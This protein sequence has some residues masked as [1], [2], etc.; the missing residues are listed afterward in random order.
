MKVVPRAVVV[1]GTASLLTDLSS[2]M[3]YPL[4]PLFLSTQ[5]GASALALGVIE[6]V[7]ETTASV[8]KIF[9]GVWTD[10]IQRRKPFIVA[11][12][13]LAG[14]ARPLV[15][16]ATAWPQVLAIR[17]CDRVGKGVRTSPRD[18]LIA[19]TVH[20]DHRGAAFGFH[21]MM[22]NAGAVLGPLVATLLLAF[23]MPLRTVFLCAIVPSILVVLIQVFFLHEA[24]VARA[25]EEAPPRVGLRAGW[26]VLDARYK[27]LLLSI[28]VFTLGAS[29]DAFILM[30]LNEAGISASTV[31]LLWSLHHVVKMVSSYFGGWISDT[32]GRRRVVL[33][34]W[35]IYAAAYVAFGYFTSPGV[36]VGVFLLYGIY[37][38]L[39]EPAERAWVAD[40][41]PKALRGTAMGYYHGVVGL[42]SL[43]A[44]ILF[45][46]VWRDYGSAAAFGMGAVFAGLGA[47]LLL[48]VAPRQAIGNHSGKG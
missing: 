43:P 18:A 36:L 20:E 4:L 38:G 14:L 3:I 1:M 44:D 13:A 10:R 48:L 15:G 34:G 40:L 19:D 46:F 6:G 45:G 7:A 26:K 41:A 27:L 37:F 42:S 30:R 33:A 32:L 17:F 8:L 21:R 47:T 5:L 9:S 12:Y 31:A 29:S 23:G 16:L 11:G 24:P 39:V 35:A 28:F 22:D 2:E 25:V